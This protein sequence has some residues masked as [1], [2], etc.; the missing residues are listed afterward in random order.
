PRGSR[1]PATAAA[2]EPPRRQRS[3]PVTVATTSVRK[4]DTL[5]QR[6]SLCRR[7]VR[8]APCADCSSTALCY[9]RGGSVD[10]LINRVRSCL[11]SEDYAA[12]VGKLPGGTPGTE[13]SAA[14]QRRMYV[15][16]S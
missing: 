14:E 9:S 13:S 5:R 6:P 4:T 12:A 2:G 16:C 11:R 1:R 3:A 8:R 15:C 10:S 7:V